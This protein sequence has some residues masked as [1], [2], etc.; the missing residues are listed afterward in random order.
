MR[1]RCLSISP[2]TNVLQLYLPGT[3]IPNNL[4]DTPC[5]AGARSTISIRACRL[6]QMQNDEPPADGLRQITCDRGKLSKDSI[7]GRIWRVHA[8]VIFF[9]KVRNQGP[10]RGPWTGWYQLLT[11]LT[12]DPLLD[13]S[14]SKAQTTSRQ[15][16]R[17]HLQT[18][19]KN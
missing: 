16:Q 9:Q 2:V 8:F 12:S 3:N 19:G 4:L 15:Q 11:S 13:P 17:P 5:T 6:D 7:S 10:K 18:F 14:K 1:L